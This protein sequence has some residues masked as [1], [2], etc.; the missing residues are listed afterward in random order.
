MKRII[1]IAVIAF[2]LVSCGELKGVINVISALT[3]QDKDGKTV[4]VPQ[5]S[6]ESE[7]SYDS[8]DRE[9]K[10]KIKK[11]NGD[12]DIKVTIKVPP[13]TLI[14]QSNGD[15]ALQ[16]TQINQP[17]DLKGT[18]NTVVENSPERQGYESC[19]YAAYEYV[20]YRVPVY[21]NQGQLIGY[22]TEYRYEYV[23]RYG[24]RQVSYFERVT[25]VTSKSEFLNPQGSARLAELSGANSNSETVYTYYGNCYR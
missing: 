10:I 1:S 7:F 11:V 4:T 20:P 9:L 18:I 3:V 15:F 19:Q 21:N 6:Y 14:P 25:T 12:K 5:G 16:S 2:A 17:W 24:R 22:R 13:N 23:T 8:G